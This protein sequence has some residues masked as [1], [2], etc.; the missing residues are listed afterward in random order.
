M[1]SLQVQEEFKVPIAP[2]AIDPKIAMERENSWHAQFGRHVDQARIS[3][4]HGHVGVLIDR[5]PQCSGSFRGPV[6]DEKH[7]S[8][9]IL[10]NGVGRSF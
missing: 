2:P 5:H 3:E 4:F 10:Q 1:P 7:A 9:D 8:L 6:G